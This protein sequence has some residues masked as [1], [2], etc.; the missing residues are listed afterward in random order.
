M[1]SAYDFLDYLGIIYSLWFAILPAA[2][3]FHCA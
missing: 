1:I 3:S 2:F